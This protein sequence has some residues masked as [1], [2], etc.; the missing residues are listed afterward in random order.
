MGYLLTKSTGVRKVSL[1]NKKSPQNYFVTL[2][3]T[4]KDEEGLITA[5]KYIIY[6]CKPQR[7][8]TVSHSSDGDPM[9]LSIEFQALEDKDGNYIDIVEVDE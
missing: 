1:N 8:F 6:K 2:F 3:T 5:K 9:S 4:D 7:Q